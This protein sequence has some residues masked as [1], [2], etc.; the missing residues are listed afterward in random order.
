MET[1]AGPAA[2]VPATTRE[3][4]LAQA[5]DVGVLAGRERVGDDIVGLRALV[6]Y[7]LKG[8]CAYAWHAQV[9]GHVREE[10]YAGVEA[11]LAFLAD[12]PSDSEALLE[13]ALALGQL[14]LT[15]ME[16]LDSA[17][18]TTFGTPEPTVVRMTPVAGKAILASG[19]DLRDL[20]ALLEATKDQGINVYT[21]GELLP[22]LAYPAFKAFPHL[23][24]NYGGAWQE[25]RVEFAAFPG[26]IVMTSNCLIKPH[27]SYAGRVFTLG[28]VGWPGVTHL[29]GDDFAPVLA[30]ARAQPGFAADAPAETVTIGFARDAVLGVA[31]TVIA[32]V[33][34]GAIRHFFLVGGCDGA[35]PGRN[36]FTEFAEWCRRTA[37]C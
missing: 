17:N 36:Y 9:L 8:V 12:G 23:V 37:S 16:T 5:A 13:Q 19:H 3:G 11:A 34:S 4:L 6:L 27:S 35:L 15:V 33:K 7:G 10:I 32:A 1:L 21:H 18:T 30:A 29:A 31:D 14:N 28:P 25:Q 20:M 2:F 26:P 24:G 22:A